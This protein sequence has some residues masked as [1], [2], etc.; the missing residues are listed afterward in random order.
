MIKALKI[1]NEHEGKLTKKVMASL[2]EENKIITINARKENQSQARFASL[3]KNIIHPLEEHWKFIDVEK[4][5]RNRW[6][7]INQEGK[8]AATFLI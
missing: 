5:G 3:D 7:K 2:A 1:L 8:N 6:I 4:I